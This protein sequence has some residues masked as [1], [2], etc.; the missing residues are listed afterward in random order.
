MLRPVPTPYRPIS[1]RRLAFLGSVLGL[2]FSAQVATAQTPSAATSDVP[3]PTIIG[4]ISGGLRGASWGGSIDDLA[5]LVRQFDGFMGFV[6]PQNG[7]CDFLIS[8]FSGTRCDIAMKAGDARKV[9]G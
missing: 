5:S 2:L 4:P 7:L 9:P 8:Y 6:I 3:A 1:W